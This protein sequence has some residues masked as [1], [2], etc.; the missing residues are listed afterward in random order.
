[1]FTVIP[2]SSRAI[3]AALPEIFL[4]CK[5]IKTKCV[6]VPP[7]I[8]LYPFDLNSSAKHWAFSNTLLIYVLNE[9]SKD[10]LKATAF[11]HK[12]WINGP[13]WIPGITAL[14]ISSDIILILPDFGATL[15]NGFS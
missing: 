1:M 7:E 4:F 15:P 10:Y 8:R 3:S 6:S 13:P 5:S 9:G 12:I 2:A 14:S 11:D